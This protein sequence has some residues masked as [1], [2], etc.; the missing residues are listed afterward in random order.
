MNPYQ[1]GSR[2]FIVSDSNG[3]PVAVPYCPCD[4]YI[5]V[6][7]N[8]NLP[9]SGEYGYTDNSFRSQ[10]T[11]RDD[12]R[13]RGVPYAALGIPGGGPPISV[14]SYSFNGSAE[15]YRRYVYANYAT[16]GETGET[17]SVSVAFVVWVNWV[18]F[19]GGASG[20]AM[21]VDCGWRW[22]GGIGFSK[23]SKTTNAPSSASQETGWIGGIRRRDRSLLVS[24]FAC[25]SGYVPGSLALPERKGDICTIVSADDG[26][27]IAVKVLSRESYVFV[28]LCIA[29]PAY[30]GPL[31]KDVQRREAKQFEKLSKCF[32]ATETLRY[33]AVTLPY[34][35]SEPFAFRTWNG[36][37][38]KVNIYG[39]PPNTCA[40]RAPDPES[41]DDLW[42]NANFSQVIPTSEMGGAICCRTKPTF[43]TDGKVVS[44]VPTAAKL[45]AAIDHI[46][47]GTRPKALLIEFSDGDF[48]MPHRSVRTLMGELGK[49]CTSLL[50]RFPDAMISIGS[51][52][53]PGWLS[54]WQTQEYYQKIGFDWDLPLFLQCRL[55]F[56]LNLTTGQI[57]RAGYRAFIR[58]AN[59]DG[60]SYQTAR[61]YAAHAGSSDYLVRN[62]TPDEFAS[63]VFPYGNNTR[64]L[65]DE[66]HMDYSGNQSGV[67]VGGGYVIPVGSTFVGHWG[68]YDADSERYFDPDAGHPYI[69]QNGFNR[70]KFLQKFAEY[71]DLPIPDNLPNSFSDDQEDWFDYLESFLDEDGRP[72]IRIDR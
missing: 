12:L 39:Q 3:S 42:H 21:L 30:V 6:D 5:F 15:D 17:V 1:V 26:N 14:V 18:T 67:L 36:I 50:Q 10:Y 49:A 71:I 48:D 4:S 27:P 9:Y 53:G 28:K 59:P 16:T 61:W 24:M 20:M 44:Y 55:N 22:G 40:R 57:G 7:Y 63:I 56:G 29:N 32:P 33:G 41:Y 60:E 8:V 13:V 46:I 45:E 25:S 11:T 58:F 65:F 35:M 69:S 54:Y 68:P 64:V 66:Y 51:Q 43:T 34:P 23:S 38:Y 31:G 2:V 62:R 19:P 37:P 47:D 72:R 52:R 70:K